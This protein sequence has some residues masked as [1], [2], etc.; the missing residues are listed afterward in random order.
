MFLSELRVVRI[1]YRMWQPLQ[2][3]G[4]AAQCVLDEDIVGHLRVL[5]QLII[6]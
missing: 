6:I 1:L 4:G 2:C 5:H 3:V